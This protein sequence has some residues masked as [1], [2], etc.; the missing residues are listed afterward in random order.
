MVKRVVSALLLLLA[1]EARAGSVRHVPVAE[2]EA[3]EALVVPASV[4][5]AFE[6]TVTLH[7]R[8]VLG[9]SWSAAEFQRQGEEWTATIPADKVDA[10]GI[11]Y[12][13]VE[14]GAD[15]RTVPAFASE[16]MP[17]R[18]VVRRSDRD[19]RKDRDLARTAGRRS[20]AAATGEWVDFGART[21]EKDGVSAE[22]PDRYYRI[23]ASYRYQLLAYPLKAFRLGYIRLLGTTPDA[24]LDDGRDCEGDVRSCDFEAGFKVGGYFELRFALVDGV[25]VDARG[26]F[27]ATSEGFNVGGRGE[28]RFGVEDGSHAALGGEVLAEVGT[29]AFFRLGWDTVPGAP[30]TAT[31]ELLDY[32]AS[33]RAT[34]VR[35]VYGIAHPFES[36]L[37][38][39]ARISYQAR[40]QVVGGAGAG[41]TASMDF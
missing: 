24:A 4:E 12:Y 6:S 17:H 16:A 5:R 33:V 31:V 30:M 32:P 13:I 15:G 22:L 9:G 8:P 39:G 41:L 14:V 7:F 35:M 3:G 11:D 2:A 26:N 25:E 27:M 20:R 1:A 36:G 29:S 28:L 10:P 37:R 19:L 23:D 34:G 40:D 21:Y 18:I 38:L